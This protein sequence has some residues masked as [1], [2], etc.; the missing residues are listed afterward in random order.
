MLRLVQ[1]YLIILGFWLI[2]LLD[3]KPIGYKWVCRRKYN[4]DGSVQAFKKILVAKDFTQK[5]GI[6]YFNTYSLVV[7]IISI[8][9]LL[10]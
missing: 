4:I 7:R 8:K 6:D 10:L 2:Y 1:Y 3:Q 9:I 5:E